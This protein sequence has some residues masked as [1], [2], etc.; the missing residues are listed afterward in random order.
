MTRS[1]ST[2]SGRSRSASA[3]ASSPSAA[4]PATSI[5]SCRSRNARSPARTTA[6]SSS[7]STRIGSASADLQA[8][9]RACT[10]SGANLED[11]AE[12]LRTLFH[13]GE[14]EP[15]RPQA[16]TARL[17]ADAVVLHLEHEASVVGVQAQDD[18]LCVRVAQRVLQ[19]LLCDAQHVAVTYSVAGNGVVDVE[20]DLALL[21]PAQHVD[22]LAQRAAQAVP[23]EVGRTELEHERAQLVERLL[24]ERLQLRNLLARRRRIALEQRRRSLGA[25]HDAEELLADRVVEVEREPVSLGDDGE[26]PALLVQPGIRDRDRGV[27][28]EQPDQ[29][30]VVAAE[31]RCPDLLG[32]VE[33]ADHSLR[34]DDRHAEE[35]AHV[36][37]AFGPP[38][39]K[40]LMLVNVSRAVRRL[41]LEH[42]A[43]HAV[44]PRQR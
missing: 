39:A 24:R 3:S 41:G 23:F 5:P 37:M 28:G 17:E 43:E 42:R 32:Q 22:V 20:V 18:V 9:R 31:V 30:L 34:R 15:P 44:L 40:A 25:E 10:G 21:Q 29:L 12:T 8:H 19:R 16:G 26:L 2:T 4:S 36:R 35:R 27:R 7:T 1:M 14:A 33:R 11:T 13:R 38:A 6:W